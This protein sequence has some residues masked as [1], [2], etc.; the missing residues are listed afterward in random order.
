MGRRGVAGDLWDGLSASL[1]LMPPASLITVFNPSWEV[2][3]KPQL[4][5]RG[6]TAQTGAGAPSE[7][8]EADGLGLWAH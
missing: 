3:A 4:Y 5:L 7:G 2:G 8:A 6:L 1:L